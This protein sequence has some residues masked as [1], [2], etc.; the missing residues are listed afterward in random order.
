MTFWKKSLLTQVDG[1]RNG[2]YSRKKRSEVMSSVKSKNTKHEIYVRS[3]LHKAGFRFRVNKYKNLPYKP[4][5]ILPKYNIAVFVH[6]CFWHSPYRKC[7]STPATNTE[8]W[9]KKFENNIDRDK[10][11]IIMLENL[12]WNIRII[13]EC[14]LKIVTKNLI[15]ELTNLKE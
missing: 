15:K 3:C 5:I 6:G 1:H 12:G 4:D 8:Y 9:Q 14:E 2:V 13:W 11:E 10:K 7:A